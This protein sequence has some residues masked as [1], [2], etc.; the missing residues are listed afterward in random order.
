MMPNLIQRATF[1]S[2][3][4]HP[5]QSKGPTDGPGCKNKP[6]P[7]FHSQ[8]RVTRLQA[9]NLLEHFRG[10]VR[11]RADDST[12]P[13]HE[14]FAVYNELQTSVLWRRRTKIAF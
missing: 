8:E 5:V 14:R 13:A 4:R 10:Q 2:G 6:C 11:S 9:G 3:Q 12:I 7:L 1:T